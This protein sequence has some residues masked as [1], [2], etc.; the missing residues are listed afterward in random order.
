MADNAL[1]IECSTLTIAW[2]KEWA[3]LATQ[4][5]V[6]ALDAPVVGS[7]PQAEAAQLVFLA[8]GDATQI[9]R[10]TPLLRAM[11]AAVHH[12]GAHGSG[13]AIKL[14]VNALFSVQVAAIA[15]LQGLLKGNGVDVTRATEIIGNLPVASPAVKVAASAMLGD[16]FAPLFPVELVEKDLEYVA[17]A[18]KAADHLAPVT[19]ATQAVMRLAI[20]RGWGAENLTGIVRLYR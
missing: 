8:G 14:A 6:T 10:A 13:A 15:E 9:E 7:R 1:A 2:V 17:A 11:G 4:R 3:R 16:S 19:D 12:C 18:A 5:G 20:A